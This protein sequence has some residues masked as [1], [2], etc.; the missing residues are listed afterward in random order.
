MDKKMG[1]GKKKGIE[2]KGIKVKSIDPLEKEYSY[3]K[4]RM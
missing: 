2:V 1:Y 3:A 4:Y